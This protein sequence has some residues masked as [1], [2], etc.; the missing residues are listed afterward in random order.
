MDG[1][2]RFSERYGLDPVDVE[3][4]IRNDAPRDLRDAVVSIAYECNFRPKT[5][6]TLVCR[7]L[8][9]REDQ[10]NWSE[11]PNID[12][13]VRQHLDACVWYDVYNIIEA[14]YMDLAGPGSV[15]RRSEFVM[16][17]SSEINRFFQMKGIGW[18]LVEGQ[19]LVRGHESF[20]QQLDSAEELLSET[21]RTIAA[22]ELREARL[23]LSRRPR[24]DITGA[25]QHAVAALECVARDVSDDDATLGSLLK[26]NP[27]LVPKPLDKAVHGIWG[28]ASE[29]GRHLQEGNAPEFAEAELLVATAA[30]VVSYLLREQ[31][32]IECD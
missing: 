25:I 31:E 7:V 28:Y 8:R 1:N 4:T 24:A 30:A 6:R 21:K 12:G 9:V 10:S 17:F 19:V 3:I 29:R 15:M 23:D 5:L 2:A 14:I 26:R 27:G 22:C 16:K 11:Y 32:H 18:Q 13:E 20:E